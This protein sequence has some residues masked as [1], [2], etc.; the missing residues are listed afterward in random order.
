VQ[1]A[2][3]NVN[4][5]RA[6]LSLVERWLSETQPDVAVLQEIKCEDEKF[7]LSELSALGYECHIH[8]QKGY[9]GVAILSK[10]PCQE[11]HKGWGDFA[12]P[13][14]DDRRILRA[15]VNGVCVVNTYVPNGNAVGNEKWQYKMA[16]LEH[17]A[18]FV[19]HLQAQ[20]DDVIWLGDIN[21]APTAL[22]V[23]EAEKKVGDVGHHPD[24]W[25]RLAKITDLSLTDCYRKFTSEPGGY[26]FYDFRLPS[27][28]KRGLGWRIDHIYATP[29]LASACTHC[30]VQTE[31]REQEKP[32]D[33]CP[34]VATFD[35]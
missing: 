22:D 16:W 24:E 11:V 27:S 28:V 19:A 3:F 30:D 14:D 17:F 9:N 5:V 8:G 33:H 1:I 26:T 34:V 4:S 32:S 25:S 10:I 6:R 35:R 29:A 23:Y 21:I 31:W 12:N 7:P 2:T 13:F 20:Y 18:G 15:V